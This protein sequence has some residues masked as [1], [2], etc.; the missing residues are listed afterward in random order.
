MQIQDIMTG[1]LETPITVEI[2]D[3]KSFNK[4]REAVEQASESFFKNACLQPQFTFDTFVVGNNN[5]NAY[6]A[7]LY[8]VNSPAKSNPIFLYSKSG[9]GKTHLIQ[10]I[11]NEYRQKHPE[12]KVLY[13]TRC[14]SLYSRTFRS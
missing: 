4:R 6:T 9:L 2:L 13:I 12:A 3:K 1:L 5:R 8:A 11:G 10:A 7:A 14:L